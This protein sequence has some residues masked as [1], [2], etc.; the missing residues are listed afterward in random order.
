MYLHCFFSKAQSTREVLKP[1]KC[2]VCKQETIKVILGP[3]EFPL[4]TCDGLNNLKGLICIF[5][6][7]G[8][9]L[10]QLFHCGN[11]HRSYC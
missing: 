9:V 2:Q 4:Y 3:T 5:Q 11:V 8:I 7:S 10:N 1:C 6:L